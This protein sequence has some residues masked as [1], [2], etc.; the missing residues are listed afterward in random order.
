MVA[1][2]NYTVGTRANPT[3]LTVANSDQSSPDRVLTAVIFGHDRAEFGTPETTLAGRQICVTGHISFFR[4][5]PEMILSTPKQV[6]YSYPLMSR[7]AIEIGCR[8]K[9]GAGIHTGMPAGARP[10]QSGAA[11]ST[12]FPGT[13]WVETPYLLTPLN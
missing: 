11:S 10:G 3:F 12:C 8:F 6:V 7:I 2:A 1:S 9:P 13:A 4:G 5:R